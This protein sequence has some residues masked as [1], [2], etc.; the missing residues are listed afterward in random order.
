MIPGIPGRS[1]SGDSEV[2]RRALRAGCGDAEGD[3]L[4]VDRIDRAH[5]NFH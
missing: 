5:D 1:N 2:M 3:T 4:V